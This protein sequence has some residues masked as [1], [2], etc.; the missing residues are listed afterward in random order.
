MAQ[1][2]PDDKAPVV[3]YDQGYF[4]NFPVKAIATEN[5]HTAH[6]KRPDGDTFYLWVHDVIQNFEIAG[7]YAQS[8]RHR[9][10]YPRNFVQPRIQIQGQFPNQSEYGRFAEWVRD[11]QMQ[12]QRATVADYRQNTILLTIPDGSPAPVGTKKGQEYRHDG[13]SV[14]GH[15]MNMPRTAERWVN[16]PEFALELVV[17]SAAA[18]VLTVGLSDPTINMKRMAMAMQF[19]SEKRP[20]TWEDEAMAARGKLGQVTFVQDPDLLLIA[21]KDAREK[22][23][24]EGEEKEQAAGQTAVG[25]VPG[26]GEVPISGK[27]V[28]SVLAEARRIDGMDLAYSWGGGH[29]KLGVPSGPNNGFDCSG[30][31]SA[32]LGAGGYIKTPLDSDA[33][34]K[35]G[36]AG[37]GTD[38]TVYANSGHAFLVFEKEGIRAD[39][40]PQSGDSNQSRG[41][42]IRSQRRSTAGFTARHF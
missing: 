27:G 35:F 9:A 3:P 26:V 33:L 30:Y 41:A 12:C 5:H 23:A 6:I 4:V 19:P 29:S 13:I 17:V 37:K 7:S 10:W 11:A 2:S 1:Y 40:S 38:F 39:T 22:A 18:G 34:M 14:R 25:A 21:Q 32:C 31:V 24:R 16:A 8:H 28:S 42:H 36:K 20:L 15:I